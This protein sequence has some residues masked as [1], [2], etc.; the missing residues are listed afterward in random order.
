[1]AKVEGKSVEAINYVFCSDQFLHEM[2]RE[3]LAHDTLTDIIT[4]DYSEKESISGDVFIS[5]D[6]TKENAQKF[7]QT[8][9]KELHRVMVH[10]LLHLIGYKDKAPSESEQM[11]AKED[12]YLSLRNF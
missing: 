12:Y 11:R 2:N 10:G 3:Y 8:P 6:R 4:F 9:L 7:H 1:M 5:L